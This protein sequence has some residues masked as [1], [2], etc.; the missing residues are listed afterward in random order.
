MAEVLITIAIIGIVAAITVPN[1]ISKHKE[2]TTVTRVNVIYSKLLEGFRLMIEENGTIDT[3]GSTSD[4]RTLKVNELL[5]KY[6]KGLSPCAYSYDCFND[7]YK[8]KYVNDTDKVGRTRI[9]TF[10]MVDGAVLQFGIDSGCTQTMAM[11]QKNEYGYAYGTY[12]M[13]CGSL[14]IDLN[15][16]LG[17]NVSDIDFFKFRIVT[18][19]IIPAGSSK[20]TVWTQTF[21][22]QCLENRAHNLG[23]C[24]AWVIANKNMDYLHCPE[25]LGWD[26]AS[27]CKQ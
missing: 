1:L 5:P 24:T 18:D 3:Y 23:N 17:P 12:G 10:K 25:K 4:E 2:K 9:A 22:D 26:K 21:L 27:S 20:E 16:R 7:L 11:D 15:G 19:G 14:V 6:I 8:F 13:G